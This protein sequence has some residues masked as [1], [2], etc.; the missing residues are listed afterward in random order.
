MPVVSGLIVSVDA[1]FIGLSL[2]LQKKC[3]FLYLAIINAFLFGLCIIGFLV[4]GR[5]YEWIQFDTDLIVGFAF[6]A[7]GLWYILQ[8][9]VSECIK[10]RKGNV[11][12]ENTSL[13]TIIIVGLVMSGEAMLMATYIKNLSDKTLEFTRVVADRFFILV[14]NRFKIYIHY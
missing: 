9:F 8:Y 14:I 1:F 11:S 5:I 3:K 12:K 6:I 7:L 4:A 2:G 13:K 10:R